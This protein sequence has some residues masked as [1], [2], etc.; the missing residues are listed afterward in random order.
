MGVNLRKVAF[1]TLGCK[2]NSYETEKI[3]ELFAQAGFAVTED[4][5]ADVVV[6]NTCT[7]T[8][9]SDKK[10]RQLLR[11][12]RRQNPNA[13]I[14]AIGCYVEALP[15]AERDQNMK[16]DGVDVALGNKDKFAIA[17]IVTRLLPPVQA[18]TTTA[19]TAAR[20]RAT[21]QIQNGCNSY[22]SY[23][24]IPYVRGELWTKP[25]AEAVAEARE[26]T[27][28]GFKEIILVGIN[29]ANY[30]LDNLIYLLEQLNELPKL[31]RI[32]LGSLEPCIMDSGFIGKLAAIP[33]LC[34]HLHISLQ[35][36]CDATLR[37]MNRSYTMDEYLQG[38]ANLRAAI[39]G[40]A[41]TT[42][43]MTGFPGETDSEFAESYANIKRA[44]FAD[45]HIFKYSPRKGTV[46]ADIPEQVPESIKTKRAAELDKL[47]KELATAFA[48]SHIGLTVTVLTEVC[49]Q[50]DDGTFHCD[51]LTP[52]YLRVRF[53]STQDL[54]G[55]IVCCELTAVGD[56]G[57]YMQGRIN[58]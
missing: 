57:E 25:I 32:R 23:C 33:K 39:P 19:F 4:E 9:T 58:E 8:A 55:E 26:F 1:V 14:A 2:V 7:V 48:Q 37:R 49:K 10:T 13:I 12:L 50:A 11:R 27:Q 18:Q 40:I 38:L 46:A 42:D 51:G 29:L 6:V 3:K 17:D 15:Q 5:N 44:A 47:K 52:D 36:G 43:V 21:L 54:T 45:I 31:E 41:I 24:I 53:N 16:A 35:S 56:N 30:G 22:C 20:H 28:R 34:P